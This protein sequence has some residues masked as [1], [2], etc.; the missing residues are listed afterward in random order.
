MHRICFIAALCSL[1]L[2]VACDGKK[3]KQ[4]HEA[5]VVANETL[6]LVFSPE[7]S[8][9]LSK[10]VEIF[11]RLDK[12]LPNGAAISFE[13]EE[14]PSVLA[15]NRIARGE[16]KAVMWIAPLPALV[17]YVNNNIVN[18]GAKQI[19]CRK[20]FSTGLV[21][22]VGRTTRKKIMGSATTID[23]AHLYPSAGLHQLNYVRP[24]LSDSGIAAALYLNARFGAKKDGANTLNFRLFPSDSRLIASL[25]KPLFGNPRIALSSEQELIQFN[26]IADENSFAN[27]IY[28]Q[29]EPPEMEYTA[30]ISESD[31]ITPPQRAAADMFQS[32]LLSQDVQIVAQQNGFRSV[33]YQTE[34]IDS[35]SPSMGVQANPETPYKPVSI[36]GYQQ[37]LSEPLQMSPQTATMYVIDCSSSMQG[38]ALISAKRLIRGMLERESAQDPSGLIAFDSRPQLISP[39]VTQKRTIFPHLTG[40]ATNAGSAVYDSILDAAEQLA[41]PEFN[42]FQRRIVLI[43]DGNDQSSQT[44]LTYFGSAL[45]R[46][47]GRQEISLLT[48]A[49]PQPD[50]NNSDLMQIT[51]LFSGALLAYDTNSSLDDFARLIE[52]SS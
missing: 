22:A 17:D 2:V 47:V 15:A 37:L 11:H 8:P 7:V 10:A 20:I 42:N 39:P 12:R 29:D 19:N 38:P 34:K 25:P 23:S 24:L 27:A 26:R 36:G 3:Q 5:K 48:L 31:W 6:K 13:R 44:T 30:C 16:V 32:H 41:K 1:I 40:L 28:I 4:T 14:L 52:Q 51:D 49:V 33:Q 46:R 18:L 45:E 43:T 9:V 21:A 35:F 50:Q